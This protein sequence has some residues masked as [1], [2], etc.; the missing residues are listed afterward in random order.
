MC[1]NYISPLHHICK[2]VLWRWV[3]L[4]AMGKHWQ[5][6]LRSLLQWGIECHSCHRVCLPRRCCFHPFAVQFQH[7]DFSK[8]WTFLVLQAGALACFLF[9]SSAAWLLELRGCC[10]LLPTWAILSC[11]GLRAVAS[12][13][14]TA[15][16]WQC[17]GVAPQQL[18]NPSWFAA[19]LLHR[20][21]IRPCE[22]KFS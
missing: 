21:V 16:V 17:S 14:N 20:E 19:L 3:L 12:G 18:L 13:G 1:C 22:H 6:P 9:L 15:L 10:G 5:H 4:E 8:L 2:L 11:W 7:T